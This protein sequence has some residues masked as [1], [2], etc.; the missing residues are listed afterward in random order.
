MMAVLLALLLLAPQEQQAVAVE[1]TLSET[2]VVAG[3]SVVLRL[4]VRTD[5]SRASIDP[6][7]GL[8]EGLEVISTRSSDQRQFSL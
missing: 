1:A 4:R 2:T 3:S 8:P 7:T 6:L 5:G